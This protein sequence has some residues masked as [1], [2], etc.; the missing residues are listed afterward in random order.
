MQHADRNQP[1]DRGQ[2]VVDGHGAPLADAEG[3]QPVRCVVAPACNRASSGHDTGQRDKR[4]IEDRNQEDQHGDRSP[5]RAVPLQR[6]DEQAD[7]GQE[8]AE[9]E[10]APVAIKKVLQRVEIM[11][12]EPAVATKAASAISTGADATGHNVSR[13]NAPAIA[14]TPAANPS[15]LSSRLKALDH[16]QQINQRGHPRGS[17]GNRVWSRKKACKEPARSQSA[18]GT[19]CRGAERLDRLR[20]EHRRGAARTM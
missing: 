10:T 17:S 7:A 3:N 11:E 8:E 2:H 9:K 1:A 4:R 6:H 16:R 19:S 18:A 20:T 5:G 12:Q 13:K 14:A 15:T